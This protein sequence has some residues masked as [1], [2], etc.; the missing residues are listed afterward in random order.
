MSLSG[1]S[2]KHSFV[3]VVRANMSSVNTDPSDNLPRVDSDGYGLMSTACVWRKVRNRLQDLGEPIYFMSANRQTDDYQSIPE[4]VEGVVGKLSD[5]KGDDAEQQYKD[6]FCAAF[7]DARLFGGLLTF[8]KRKDA[9]GYSIAVRS[10]LT[11]AWGRTKDILH[12][13]THG[14][15]K[16]ANGTIDDKADKSGTVDASSNKMTSDRLGSYTFVQDAYY[17]FSGSVSTREGNR[18]G[19]TEEDL[20]KFKVALSSMFEGDASC[21]RP[22]GSM[23]LTDFV[24]F[25]QPTI[26]GHYSH[27]RIMEAVNISDDGRIEVNDAA[28]DKDKLTYEHVVCW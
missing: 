1:L 11:M 26:D 22:A 10:P 24:W 3:F 4:R 16:S 2:R 17:I 20:E 14:I 9:K 27:R 23:Y 13:E 15:T 25:T 5:F 7:L 6:A 19:L 8:P 12:F 18:V 21:A 28:F